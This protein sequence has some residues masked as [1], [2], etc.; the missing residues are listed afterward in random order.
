MSRIRVR[1]LETQLPEIQ[2][3]TLLLRAPP[4]ELCGAHRSLLRCFAL[5]RVRNGGLVIGRHKTCET[6]QIETIRLSV[7]T[8]CDSAGTLAITWECVWPVC[9]ACEPSLFLL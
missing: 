3:L 6:L 9:A 8:R 2:D 7:T 5:L 4:Y 1:V